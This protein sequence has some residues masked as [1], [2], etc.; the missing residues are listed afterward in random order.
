MSKDSGKEAQNAAAA[1]RP[2][3][4]LQRLN[5]F[6]GLWVSEWRPKGAQPALPFRIIGTDTYEWMPGNFFLVHT[7]DVRMNDEEQRVTELIGDYTPSTQTFAMRSFDN[8]GS[9][10]TMQAS[11][12]DDGVWS[13]V[14]HAIRAS[15]IISADGQTME[16]QWEQLGDDAQWR[17]WMDMRFTRIR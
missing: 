9:F 17:P 8:H 7:V 1:P 15:L 6:V 13:F 11:V 14:G 4:N 12:D 16:A 5:A 2:D 10:Q 3:P